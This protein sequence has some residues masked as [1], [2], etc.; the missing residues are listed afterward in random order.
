MENPDNFLIM[1]FGIFLTFTMLPTEIFAD[2]ADEGYVFTLEG[3]P[4]VI[5]ER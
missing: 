5:P 3:K 2:S 4:I 1:A